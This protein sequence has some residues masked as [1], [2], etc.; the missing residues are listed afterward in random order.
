MNSFNQ[1]LMLINYNLASL[2]GMHETN[3]SFTIPSLDDSKFLLTAVKRILKRSNLALIGTFKRSEFTHLRL[4]GVTTADNT[5]C[6]VE[7]TT[8][9]DS[10][11]GTLRV[12]TE[13]VALGIQLAED[14]LV[15]LAGKINI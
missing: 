5:C 13:A 15:D 7:V 14:L 9:H 1:I 8:K 4:A 6:L 12:N 3:K 11:E 2:R 10:N